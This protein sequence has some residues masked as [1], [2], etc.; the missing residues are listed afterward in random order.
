MPQVPPGEAP[1]PNPAAPDQG[2]PAVSE[3]TNNVITIVCRAVSLKIT[4]DP[5]ANNKDIAYAVRDQIAASPLVN[6]DSKATQLVG[7]ISP[8][9]ANGTFTFTVNVT[10]LTPLNF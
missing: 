5:S 1:P 10:P 9:D 2:G 3:A 8:D 4:V 6:P 7:E